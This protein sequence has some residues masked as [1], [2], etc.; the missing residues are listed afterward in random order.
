MGD[1]FA[2][3]LE[4]L[5]NGQGLPLA[6]PGGQSACPHGRI[7]I[8]IFFDGT[9][10]NMWTDLRR[11]QQQ[12][13]R[14]LQAPNRDNGATNVAYLYL[15]YGP[16][17]RPILDKAYHHGVGTDYDDD[18]NA[19]RVNPRLDPTMRNTMDERPKSQ[20]DDLKDNRLGTAVGAGGKA[21]I[22][23]GRRILAE[24]YSHQTN[25]L[26]PEKYFDVFGFSRG[27]ALARDFANQV[28]TQ[29]IPNLNKEIPNAQ[30]ATVDLDRTSAVN[31]DKLYEC[32][33]PNTITPM[34]MGIYDTVA[35]FG[36]GTGEFL[37]DVDHTYVETCVHLV[38][39]DEFRS[40]FPLTSL[41]MDPKSDPRKPRQPGDDPADPNYQ[42]PRNYKR[43]MTEVWYPGCHSDIGGSYLDRTGPSRDDQKKG[44]LKFITLYDMWRGMKKAKVP[45]EDVSEPPAEVKRLYSE[46]CDFRENKDWA[47]HMEQPNGQYIHSFRTEEYMV[48][49]F[50]PVPERTTP[51]R[52]GTLRAGMAGFYESQRQE[53]NPAWAN[54]APRMTN[55]A[56]RA[57][58]ERYI[59]D[60]LT[61]MRDSHPW[62]L[63]LASHADDEGN[64]P[65]LQ[66]TVLMSGAQRRYSD[67]VLVRPNHLPERR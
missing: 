35:M 63:V 49:M 65:R 23:W 34:F 33:D 59:H 18:G 52:R 2:K 64:I 39:E 5:E 66:R 57:L 27:A 7:R 36:W 51:V 3:A 44:D 46:Y 43:W 58:R 32:F 12:N 29:R 24:F 56:Y 26:A 4:A 1:A 21:R 55:P 15:K 28:R 13:G 17:Q 16:R 62:L 45:T 19:I 47:N 31:T 14:P 42:N 53:Q 37:L 60:S 54:I 48:R 67:A 38:A 25:D 8:G 40:Q 22:E 61:E 10:N 41:F 30:F 6:S 9:G 11:E 50:G 20:T